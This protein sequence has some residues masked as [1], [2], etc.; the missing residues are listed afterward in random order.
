MINHHFRYAKCNDLIKGLQ[1]V[2]SD[3]M[4]Y[5]K[6]QVDVLPKINVWIPDL[7]YIDEKKP[8]VKVLH[9]KTRPWKR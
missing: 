6:E 9:F 7:V 2:Y 3:L 5:S 1:S 8:E 4:P